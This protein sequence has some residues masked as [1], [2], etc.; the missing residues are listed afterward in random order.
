[1]SAHYDLMPLSS[2]WAEPKNRR[3]LED[4]G[5]AMPG[6]WKVSRNPTAFEVRSVVQQFAEGSQINVEGNFHV[7]GDDLDAILATGE[8]STFLSVEDYA[9]DGNEN[10]PRHISFLY[11]AAELVLMVCERLAQICGPFLL[12]MDGAFF[13]IVNAGTS[14]DADW[15]SADF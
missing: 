3:R 13:V 1:M 14:P 7:A 11:G 15:V 10:M 9:K 12:T 6:D 2:G 8:D 5:L 4:M